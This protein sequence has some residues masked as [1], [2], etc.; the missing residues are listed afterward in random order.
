[1][2]IAEIL[3]ESRYNS[4]LVVDVQ[5]A[6]N[7]WC[8]KIAPG[9]ANLLNQQANNRIVLFNAEGLTDDT[10]QS[11]EEYLFDH[12]LDPEKSQGIRYIEKSYGFFRSW[13]D[14]GVSE[15]IIIKT[16]RAMVQRRVNDSRDLDVDTVLTKYEQDRGLKLWKVDWDDEGIYM[17]DFMPISLLKQISPF[18]MCG[19]GREQCLK[20][21]ELICNAFN[22]RYK[23][24]DGLLY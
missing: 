23:R 11:V 16:I 1:M 19:G 7:R 21:I 3:T 10:K 15:R 13:M 5:P 17:P 22:I 6:Y 8:S 12:G 4:T 20:E 2:R 9:V 24:I 18:L 14:A